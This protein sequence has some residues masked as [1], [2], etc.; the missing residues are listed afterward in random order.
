MRDAD[1]KHQSLVAFAKRLDSV[2]CSVTAQAT[3][4]GHLFGSVG[5]AQIVEAL[6][7]EGHEIAEAMVHLEEPI[8]ET[9]VYA[10][11]MHL[12]PDVIAT[13]R[14]WVVAD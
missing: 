14:L 13:T 5:P 3:D 8:K 9:G 1:R 6:A 12:A 10:I 2:S 11:E 4:A 7:Q